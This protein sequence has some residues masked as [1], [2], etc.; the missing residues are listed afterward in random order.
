MTD[1][2]KQFSLD[3]LAGNEEKSSAKEDVGASA[4]DEAFMLYSRPIIKSLSAAPNNSMRVSDLA[5]TVNEELPV[6]DFDTFRAIVNRLISSR[7]VEV[8]ESDPFGGN[9]LIR[10]RKG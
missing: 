2:R 1:I 8:V 7:F 9:E 3:W 5:R 10:L 6:R 4:L